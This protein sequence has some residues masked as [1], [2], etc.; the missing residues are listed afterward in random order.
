[1]TRRTH[2][3][4]KAITTTILVAAVLGAQTVKAE[5]D[6][7]RIRVG[8][9]HVM[10]NESA[11]LDVGGAP[12]EGGNISSNDNTTLL[13]EIGYRFT[14]Q[15]SAGLTIGYPPTATI[16][17]EGTAAA[18]G[19]LGEA[20]YA[21]AAMTL[22]YQFNTNSTFKPYVGAGA[23]YFVVLDTNDGA[24]AGLDVD[25]AWGSVLQTGVE[26][27]VSKKMDVF[28][29]VK[30][31]FLD[32]TATGSVTAFGGAPATADMTLDPLVIQIGTAFNF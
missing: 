12:L 10:F 30:K 32:T 15:W 4:V 19:T 31:L 2:I 21:P 7:W 16:Q 26:Y 5:D 1:M 20:T 8:P 25:N 13:A 28:V 29:D 14:P 11:S 3:G 24:L 27:K 22:Q 18:L 6:K 17:G 23:V 9:G